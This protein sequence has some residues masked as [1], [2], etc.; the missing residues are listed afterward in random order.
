VGMR[1]ATKHLLNLG[2]RRLALISGGAAR[3][4][5]ERRAAIEE[6][7]AGVADAECRVYGGDFSVDHGRRATVEILAQYPRPTAII[8]GGNMLMEGALLTL[9]EAGV[10]VG[11]DLSFVGCDNI[12]VAEIHEPPIAVIRRDVR[13][14]GVAA[15]ELLLADLEPTGEHAGLG[16]EIVLGTEF[17]VRPSCAPVPA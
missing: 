17:V 16:R 7:L 4:A 5:R 2:H 3:P 6:T 15:A 13:A 8:A 11:R 1:I 10:R 14:I 9:K 12:A